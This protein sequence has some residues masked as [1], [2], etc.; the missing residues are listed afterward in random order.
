M[1]FEKVTLKDSE[2]EMFI[3]RDFFVILKTLSNI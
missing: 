1:N 3:H 2:T